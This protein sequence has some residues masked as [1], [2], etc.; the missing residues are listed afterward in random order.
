MR[1]YKNCSLSRSPEKCRVSSQSN[2]C[3][4]YIRRSYAYNLTLFSLTRQARIKKQRK[5]KSRE[6]KAALAKFTYLQAKVD[7]LERKKEDIF[8]GELQNITK[9]EQDEGARPY[10][11]NF[12]FN[13]PSEQLVVED[14][15]DQLTLHFSPSGTVRVGLGS[16]ANS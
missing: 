10:S 2:K 9:L 13:L 5:E 4:E 12:L 6:A 7:T 11:T 16:S 3:I 14:K 8:T 1:S 15:F